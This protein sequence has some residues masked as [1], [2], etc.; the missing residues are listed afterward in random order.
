M[1]RSFNCLFDHEDFKNSAEV[2]AHGKRFKSCEHRTRWINRVIR[3]L[4]RDAYRSNQRQARL[5]R[6]NIHRFDRE[7]SPN[8]ERVHQ[9]IAKMPPDL[10]KIL[11]LQLTRSTDTHAAEIILGD[12]SDAARVRLRRIRLEQAYPLFKKLWVE[13]DF[14]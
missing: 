10:A 4:M 3:N 9:I 6:E 1:R 2:K 11:E 5:L 13:A 14:I 7:S 8:T 12:S